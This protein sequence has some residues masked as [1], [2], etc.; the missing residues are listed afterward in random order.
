MKIEI[1]L[2]IIL[3][4]ILFFLLKKIELYTLFIIFIFI[5]EIMH[6]LVGMLVGFIPKRFSFNPLG[7]SVEFYNYNCRRNKFKKIITYLAG[8]ISN[9]FMSYLFYK[10]NINEYLKMKIIYTNL[11]LGVFNLFPILPLDGGKIFKEILNSIIGNKNAIIF[12]ITV[13]KIILFLFSIIYSIAIFKIKNI[14][15]FLILMYMWYLYY[16]ECKKSKIL[17]RAYD[18]IGNIS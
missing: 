17:I 4:A 12:M 13:T 10:L 3:L 9:F 18:V 14:A 2:K 5:H 8:P 15:I 11:L 1:D 6:L 7:F 16:L